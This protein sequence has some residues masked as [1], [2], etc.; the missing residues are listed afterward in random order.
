[1]NNLLPLPV[2][3]A[4]AGRRPRSGA[5]S[6]PGRPA[7]RVDLGRARGHVRGR[8]AGRAVRPVRAGG[9][10]GRRLAPTTRDRPG[11]RSAVVVDAAGLVGG[12]A[13]RAAVLDGI[14]RGRASAG[15]SGVDLPPD[16]AGAAGGSVQRLPR[17]RSVQPVRRVRDAVVRLLRPAHSRRDRRPGARRID[18]R[19][20]QP[21]VLQPVPGG[22]P[23]RSTQPPAR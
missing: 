21:A 10:V 4:A 22:H 16:T 20:G 2:L 18:L 14:A 3:A 7:G 11:G 5:E 8:G 1:M 13:G 12:D 23:R 6:S 19:G 15:D 9:A 17:R